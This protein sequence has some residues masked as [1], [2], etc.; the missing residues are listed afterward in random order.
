MC[1]T[2]SGHGAPGLSV[3]RNSCASAARS[4]KILQNL[5]PH[6]GYHFINAPPPSTPLKSRRFLRVLIPLHIPNSSRINTYKKT[7]GGV[8]SF[9][10]QSF[11]TRHYPHHVVVPKSGAPNLSACSVCHALCRSTHQYHSIGL[12]LPLFSY[13]YALCCTPRSGNSFPLNHFR[14]LS[15]KHRGAG[16][17]PPLLLSTPQLSTVSTRCAYHPLRIQEP[18]MP[19]TVLSTLFRTIVLALR[20]ASALSAQTT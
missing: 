8:P 12:T 9:S 20:A 15:A 10:L 3:P 19:N 16:H 2:V 6:P 14:T 7:G 1:Y 13:S 18:S 5:P 17:L 11:A 4:F